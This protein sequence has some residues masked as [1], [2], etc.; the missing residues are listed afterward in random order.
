MKNCYTIFIFI[1]YDNFNNHF[2]YERKYLLWFIS[3]DLKK[4]TW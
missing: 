1:W 3:S 2:E 4:V